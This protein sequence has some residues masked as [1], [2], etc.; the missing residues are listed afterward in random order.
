[1]HRDRVKRFERGSRKISKSAALPFRTLA[2]NRLMTQ[3][4]S[5]AKPVS[6]FRN[7]VEVFSPCPCYSEVFR[8]EERL[9]ELHIADRFDRCLRSNAELG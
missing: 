3:P 8:L 6:I 1:M 5:R 7:M 9:R 4:I 2:T